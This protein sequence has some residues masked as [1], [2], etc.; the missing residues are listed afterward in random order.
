[1][2]SE[3]TV[4]MARSVRETFRLPYSDADMPVHDPCPALITGRRLGLVYPAP[5]FV[6]VSPFMRTRQTL[7]L[8][9]QA[10]PKLKQKRVIVDARIQEQDYGI[11]TQYFDRRVFSVL[12]PSEAEKMRAEGSTYRYPDGES[13]SDV[14]NRVTEWSIALESDYG[15]CRVLVISHYGVIRNL[16]QILLKNPLSN[17]SAITPSWPCEVS[18]YDELDSRWNERLF[19]TKWY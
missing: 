13:Q 5:D 12:C 4:K 19:N 6:F 1:M 11:A 2:H 3:E 16:R 15:G 17:S 18:L 8:I 10:W 14:C 9:M 7:E